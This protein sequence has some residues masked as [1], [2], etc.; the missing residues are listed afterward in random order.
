MRERVP[1]VD[2]QV[3]FSLILRHCVIVFELELRDPA[4][5]HRMDRY[6][7]AN[8]LDRQSKA[9]TRAKLAAPAPWRSTYG[10]CRK[11]FLYKQ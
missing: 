9:S 5:G 2:S 4:S 10:P 1:G 11:L 8:L 6:N 7:L 3:R